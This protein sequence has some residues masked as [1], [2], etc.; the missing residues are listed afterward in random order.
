MRLRQVKFLVVTV[1]MALHL[2]VPI[3]MAQDLSAD[4]K[5]ALSIFKELIE[6]NTVT[7]SGDTLEAAQAMSRHLISAG[8]TPADVQVLSRA[9]RKGNLVARL[10]GTG[11]LRPILLLAHLDVVEARRE[12][13]STDPFKLTEKDGFFYG[14]GVSDDKFMAASFLANLIRY[15]SEK[16]TPERDIILVL[17]TDEEILDE[18]SVGIRWLLSEHR[19]LLDA[20]F[21][22]NEGGSVGLVNGKAIVN[23]FQTSEK[24]SLNFRLLAKNPGGH[25]SLPTKENAIYRLADGLSRLARHDFPVRLNETT[26]GF[27]SQTA[28]LVPPG[29]G[30]DMRAVATTDPDLAAAGRLSRTPRYNSLLRTTCVATEL[31]GGHAVNALPQS[32]QAT[33]NCRILPNDLASEVLDT[34]RNVINDD[35]ILIEQIGSPVLSPPSPLDE[36]ILNVVKR[37]SGEFW[38]GVPIVP[39]MLA[40]AT[41]GMFL[42]SAGIPTYG[43]SGLALDAFDVRAHGKDER[44]SVKS[45]LDGHHYLY[46]LVKELASPLK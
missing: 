15:K 42:R 6:I 44:V 32:A 23:T 41:D 8:F 27:F 19:D 28:N 24:I 34:L 14:R 5:H 43:H 31:N 16:L 36:Q 4:Q 10:R 21:A 9:P 13:W 29:T 11:A 45:F 25:S 22:L 33:I 37:V 7:N 35:Q 3:A 39:T 30:A 17:E 46:K 1:L 2:A 20:D 40:A 12:D 18:N 38:P 26:K